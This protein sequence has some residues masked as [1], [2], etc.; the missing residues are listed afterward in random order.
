[1]LSVLDAPAEVGARNTMPGKQALEEVQ[2]FAIRSIA[3]GM[4]AQLI[5]MLQRQFG[6]LFE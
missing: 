6:C 2:H 4:Y 5:L 3:N 1:M